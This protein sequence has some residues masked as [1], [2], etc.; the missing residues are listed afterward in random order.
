MHVD[1]TNH[2]MQNCISILNLYQYW[3]ANFVHYIWCP[4]IQMGLLNCRDHSIPWFGLYYLIFINSLHLSIYWI[5]NSIP[6]WH[7]VASTVLS[8]SNI[9][10]IRS[11]CCRKN[12]NKKNIKIV[13]GYNLFKKF[14]KLWNENRNKNIDLF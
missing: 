3:I 12:L 14:N 7:Q 2:D 8:I 9:N 4:C 1:N 10:L 11:C 5:M 6:K 13:N